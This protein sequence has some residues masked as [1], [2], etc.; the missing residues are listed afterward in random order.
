M[1]VDCQ[2]KPI[3]HKNIEGDC[4]HYLAELRARQFRES[5]GRLPEILLGRNVRVADQ[6]SGHGLLLAPC[7]LPHASCVGLQFWHLRAPQPA[8]FRPLWNL[9]ATHAMEQDVQ[10]ESHKVVSDN[11]VRVHRV[12]LCEKEAKE[13]TLVL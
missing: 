9:E 11:H 5:V 7:R 13:G 8:Q 4:H 2:N 6:T 3:M 10:V 1:R 12:H